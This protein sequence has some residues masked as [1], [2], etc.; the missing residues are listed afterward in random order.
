MEKKTRKHKAGHRKWAPRGGKVSGE[1]QG[2]IMSQ[3]KRSA[4][5]SRIKGKDTGPEKAIMGELL[6]LGLDFETHTR[7][8]PG[9][10]D[11]VFRDAKIAIYI[12][13]DFWHGWRLPL[14]EHKLSPKWRDKIQGNRERDIRNHKKLRQM[15]WKMIRIW[16]H[17]VE[18]DLGRCISRILLLLADARGNIAP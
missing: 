1:H 16:E 8:L 4:L 11:I 17:Q 3:E 15:G 9:R 12:D 7:D 13:G 10:P 18:Q 2:D 5:M 6:L 14:W